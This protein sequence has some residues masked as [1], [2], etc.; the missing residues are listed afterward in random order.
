MTPPAESGTGA[1]G[2]VPPPAPWIS[3]E[4][5]WQQVESGS[6]QVDLPAWER[7]AAGTTGPVLDL[8]CGTGRVAHHLAR[9]GLK[10]IGIERDPGIAADFNRVA[11]ELDAEAMTGDVHDLPKAVGPVIFDLILGPQQLIQILGGATA[12]RRLLEGV[13]SRL[14][15]GGRVAFALVPSL[16]ERS[17][18]LDLLPDIRE[19]AG[20]IYSSRPVSIEA[21]PDRIEIARLRSRVSPDGEFAES[22][23]VT[24]F[25]RLSPAGL[26][27]ELNAVSLQIEETT[28]LPATDEHVAS[29]ILTARRPGDLRPADGL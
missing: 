10:V 18:A 20:W 5:V 23:E 6:Y 25:D 11:G 9:A 19:A 14:A 24:G 12:R 7:I 22:V 16:P 15:P 27:A 4:S 2:R 21:G 28:D 3:E 13:A 17:V 26:T 1:S 29:V 8:G